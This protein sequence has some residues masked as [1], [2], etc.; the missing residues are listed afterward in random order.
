[1]HAQPA[2]DKDASAMLSSGER[3]G[4]WSKEAAVTDFTAKA[5][6]AVEL[7]DITD[8]LRSR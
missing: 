1:V 4:Y 6:A 5:G 2:T 3:A 8:V 7:P